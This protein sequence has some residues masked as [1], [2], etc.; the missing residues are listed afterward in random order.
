MAN[1]RRASNGGPIS[2]G[3]SVRGRVFPVQTSIKAALTIVTMAACSHSGNG[4]MHLP[5]NVGGIT[6]PAARFHPWVI[7]LATARQLKIPAPGVE[8]ILE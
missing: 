8:F 4:L 6:G 3:K 7:A 2:R 5:A 1:D